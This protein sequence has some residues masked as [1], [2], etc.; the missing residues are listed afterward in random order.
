MLLLEIYKIPVGIALGA[1]LLILA[2]SVFASLATVRHLQ[3]PTEEPGDKDA[4][5][6]IL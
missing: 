2:S 6:K 4:G 5:N 3:R 1:V